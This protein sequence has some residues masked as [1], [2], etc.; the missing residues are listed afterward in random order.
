MPIYNQSMSAQ[1]S[2]RTKGGRG[3]AWCGGVATVKSVCC[4]EKKRHREAFIRPQRRHGKDIANVV[5]A[6]V[7]NSAC[8]IDVNLGI[9]KA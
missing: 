2:K 9:L 8:I 3:A 4:G 6:R 7:I 1:N 5:V